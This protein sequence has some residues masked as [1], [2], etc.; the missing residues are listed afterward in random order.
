MCASVLG[1]ECAERSLVPAAAM[2]LLPEVLMMHC[3]VG[4]HT[5]ALGFVVTFITF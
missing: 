4:P 2:L 1:K 3:Y 5:V